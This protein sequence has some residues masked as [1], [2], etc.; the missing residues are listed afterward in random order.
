MVSNGRKYNNLSQKRLENVFQETKMSKG[1][2]SE[3]IKLKDATKYAH[4]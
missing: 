3:G 1:N 2:N 4:V